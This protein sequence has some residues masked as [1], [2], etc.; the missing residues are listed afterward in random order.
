M[1][2][3]VFIIAYEHINVVCC[4]FKSICMYCALCVCISTSIVKHTC[5]AH[6]H[7]TVLLIL[8]QWLDISGELIYIYLLLYVSLLSSAPYLLSPFLFLF[9]STL[10][11]FYFIYSGFGRTLDLSL[12]FT[13]W[14]CLLFSLFCVPIFLCHS[15][16]Y[17]YLVTLRSCTVYRVKYICKSSCII[18]KIFET[19]IIMDHK[20]CTV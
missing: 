13:S 16:F 19:I 14:C 9:Q 2:I 3:N 15:R 17:T 6:I 12:T 4:E 1:Y 20:C 8:K 11:W 10:N 5:T 18:I 7:T